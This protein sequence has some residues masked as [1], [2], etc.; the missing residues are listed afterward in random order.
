MSRFAWAIPFVLLAASHVTA[1]DW[2]T[3]LGPTQDGVSPEK[4]VTPWP[5]EGLRKVWECELGIGFAPP[6]VAGGRLFHFDRFDDTCR[7][8]CREAATG[9]FLW[10]YEYPTQY[11]DRYG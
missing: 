1:A 8:T 3:F 5:K 9:K 6:V 10:K 7:L 11:E 2:P 4:G